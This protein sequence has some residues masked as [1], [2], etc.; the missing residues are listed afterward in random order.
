MTL[1]KFDVYS[2]IEFQ[3]TRTEEDCVLFVSKS[4]RM[5]QTLN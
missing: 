2:D 1:T 4:E 5:F 3:L